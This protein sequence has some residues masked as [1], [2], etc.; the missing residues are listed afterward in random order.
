L[1]HALRIGLIGFGQVGQTFARHLAGQA[2]VRVYDQLFD[3]D[4]WPSDMA[5]RVRGANVV[6]CTSPRE[7]VEGASLIFSLVNSAV[8]S[9]V[10]A[11]VVSLISPQ[12]SLFLDLNSAPPTAKERSA[13]EFPGGGVSYVDGGI[14]GSVSLQRHRVPIVLSGP[15]AR[16]AAELLTTLGMAPR[17]VSDKV[18]AASAIKICRSVVMKGLECLLI[19]ALLAA[20]EY[21]VSQDVL[22][23]LEDTLASRPFSETVRML[24]TTHAVHAERRSGEMAGISEALEALQIPPIMSRAAERRLSLSANLNPVSKGSPPATAEQVIEAL[25]ASK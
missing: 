14:L 6:P 22:A 2:Q 1:S 11:Q 9:Q 18:G 4:P 15:R 12:E 20:Q 17:Y 24:V 5:E 16:Q 10:A 19:E 21:D 25:K 13:L 3:R 7:A 8:S 23:S